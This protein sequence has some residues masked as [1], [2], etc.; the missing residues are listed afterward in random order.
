MRDA[1]NIAVVVMDTARDSDVTS[2]TAPTITDLAENGTRFSNAFS[3]APWTLPSHASMFT[4]LYPSKHGAHA[5]HER[6]GEQYSTLAELLGDAGYETVGITN[7]T[8]VTPESGFARGF[9]TYRK[10]WQL[11]P[12]DGNMLWE[13][14]QIRDEDSSRGVLKRAFSGNPVRNLVNAA[15]ARYMYGRE[16]DGAARTGRWVADWLDDRDDDRPFFLFANCIEPHLEYTPPQEYAEKF[17]PDDVDY[18]DAASLEQDPWEYLV[19]NVNHTSNEFDVLRAL[20][21]AEIAYLDEQ[22]ADLRDALVRAGEWEDTVLVVV[23]DHG[24]NV[25]DHGMMDHQYCLYDTLLHVPFVV[26]GG[27]FEDGGDVDDLASLVDLL[28]TLLDVADV[29]AAD[30]REEFQGRS[31]HPDADAEPPEQVFAEYVNPQPSMDALEHHVGELPEYVYRFDRS[32]RAVRTAEYKFIRGSDGNRELYHVAED[33]AERSSLVDEHPDVA[34]DLEAHLDEWLGSFDHAET[35]E[36]D[37]DIS[38]ARKKQLEELGY[39]Q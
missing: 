29:D 25:G 12:G 26:H 37:V 6:L 14:V 3:P 11:L 24:E 8:W 1:S 31:L 19:G 34:A 38:D 4:G 21:R 28:P 10:A 7:N 35:G 23:G 5:G 39:L 33:S 22:I 36:A 30:A 17:L 18:A 32:L 15:Y 27:A 2:S 16:D 13:M 20:Y 9:E